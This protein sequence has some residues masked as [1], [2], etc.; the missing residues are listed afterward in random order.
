MC[1]GCYTKVDN[2]AGRIGAATR[3]REV[4]GRAD[5]LTESSISPWCSTSTA[6]S[7]NICVCWVSKRSGNAVG[8]GV[9]LSAGRSGLRPLDT[10]VSAASRLSDMPKESLCGAASAWVS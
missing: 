8:G 7:R 5:P 4:A 2:D 3:K 10:G 1:N 9:V 6:K